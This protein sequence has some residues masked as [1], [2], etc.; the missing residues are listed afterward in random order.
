MNFIKRA[1]TRYILHRHAIQ[2]D[3]WHAVTDR[4]EILRGLTAVEKAHLR[5]LSTLF[6]HQKTIIGIDFPVTDEIRVTVAAQ[7]CLPILYLGLELLSGWTDIVIYPAAFHV[8]RDEID[9]SGVVHRQ[10]RLLSGEAWS[11][12]PVVLSWDDV[13][14]DIRYIHH[15]HNVIIHEIAHKLDM[16]DGSSNG[17]P[18]LHFKM[19][20]PEW[21]TA[22]SEAYALLRQRVQQ[23]ELTCV[24]PYAASS[25]AEFFAVFS[26]Y[27]F[28]A[29]QILAR[30]FPLVYQQLQQYYRQD[31]LSR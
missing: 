29:P 27:F 5:E 22:L 15:G 20:I 26:E 6:L 1:K 19:P 18:P 14:Q 23:H 31:P 12:G 24:N 17:M 11:R 30:H 3:V 4:L 2:H 13:E 8:N 28:S 9:D 25:P 10:A 16:L 7:A 21:T